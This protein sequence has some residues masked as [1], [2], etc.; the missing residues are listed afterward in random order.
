MNKN[1]EELTMDEILEQLA[2][3]NRLY[4]KKRREDEAYMQKKRDATQRYL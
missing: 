4:Y 3:Y 1:P 2:I